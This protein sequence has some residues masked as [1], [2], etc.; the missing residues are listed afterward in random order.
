MADFKIYG[1]TSP[2]VS[3][4]GKMTQGI[5]FPLR[6]VE[7][8]DR[9]SISTR[10]VMRGASFVTQQPSSTDSPI[11]VEFGGAQSVDEFDLS[12]GGI[13]TCKIAGEYNFRVRLEF[14]RTGSPGV[15]IVLGRFL[16]NGF[17]AGNT[18]LAQL[19]DSDTAIPS[20]FSGAVSLSVN[21]EL[22]VEIYRDSA[23]GNSGGLFPQAATLVGWGD[24][25]SASFV[26]EQV[27]AVG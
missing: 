3:S 21:D 14:G 7:D 15:S 6:D 16:V 27:S 17:Q 25:P 13:I 12:V 19:D 2:V 8:E 4:L 9:I 18:I 1:G 24:S 5:G 22:S 11:T 23:G 26:I 10:E 20:V